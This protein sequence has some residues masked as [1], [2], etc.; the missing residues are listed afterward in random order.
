MN[1]QNLTC[2][3][4]TISKLEFQIVNCQHFKPCNFKMPHLEMSRIR[5]LKFQNVH[6][7][8]FQDSNLECSR[9][10]SWNLK[11]S[12]LDISIFE[13][14]TFPKSNPATSRFQ[15]LKVQSFKSCKSE[16]RILACCL[17][18][19][20]KKSFLRV[21]T[22]SKDDDKRLSR[23]PKGFNTK[24]NETCLKNMLRAKRGREGVLQKKCIRDQPLHQ[25]VGIMEDLVQA[26][27][28]LCH[29]PAG[30]AQRS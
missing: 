5:I 20:K 14:L 2:W 17:S 10:G 28:C 27:L 15:I 6:I 29:D 21:A 4:F 25:I 11:S 23:R 7:L 18:V 24:T 1:F 9:S 30:A 8:K 3:A 13:M 26:Q 22:Q 19:T 16:I 12:N